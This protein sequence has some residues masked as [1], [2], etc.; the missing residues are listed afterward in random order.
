MHIRLLAVVIAFITAL[1]FATTASAATALP[2]YEPFPSTYA[3]GT[4]LNSN[5]AL[6]GNPKAIWDSGT[7]TELLVQSA[8]YTVTPTTYPNTP[9]DTQR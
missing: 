7:G 8:S 4:A 3:D 6:N 2:F 1:G 5:A 9:Y